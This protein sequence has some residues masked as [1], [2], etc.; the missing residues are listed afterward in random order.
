MTQM[1]SF[2]KRSKNENSSDTADIPLKKRIK[3]MKCR[4]INFVDSGF[5]E[6]CEA[7][8]ADDLSVLKKLKPVNYYALK[9]RYIMGMVYSQED[10]SENYIQFL[11]FESEHQT[12]KSGIYPLDGD[13]TSRLLAKVG[14]IIEFKETDGSRS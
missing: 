13:V 4:K 10:L 6:L 14:I 3:D 8:K 9:D 2:F 5:D 12:G 1:F 11:H 7:M